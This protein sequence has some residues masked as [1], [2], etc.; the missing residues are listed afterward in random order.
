MHSNGI[1]DNQ[2]F[3]QKKLFNS[4]NTF[5]GIQTLKHAFNIKKMCDL[6]KPKSILDFGAGKSGHYKQPIIDSE[7]NKFKNLQDYWSGGRALMTIDTYEPGIGQS[8]PSKKYDAVICTDVIEHIYFGDIFWIIK[9][10]FNLAESFVY[11]NI[12]CKPTVN[13]FL[14]NGEN[15]HITIR[16][17]HYWNGVLDTVSSQYENVDYFLSCSFRPPKKKTKYI[18]FRRKDLYDNKM[19]SVQE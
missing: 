18:F 1:D 5:A 16:N 3:A 8:I 9:E 4:Q 11:L 2:N 15:A 19:F 7:G 14:P 12:A 17:P 6:H 13:Y 10:L